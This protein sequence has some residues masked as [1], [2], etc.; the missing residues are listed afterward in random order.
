MAAQ[1][2]RMLAIGV[3]ID[4]SSQAPGL[5]LTSMTKHIHVAVFDIVKVCAEGKF[6]GGV[7]TFS[8]KENGVGFV[9]NDNNGLI[10]KEEIA[11]I[12]EKL[13]GDLKRSAKA[14]S[15]VE[16]NSDQPRSVLRHL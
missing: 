7:K 12:L 5:V 3:D 11:D 15:G 6:T 8:L 2:R 13:D 9:Y 14:L 4:Q 16:L 10:S 1:K